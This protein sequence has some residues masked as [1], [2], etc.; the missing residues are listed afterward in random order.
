MA[1]LETLLSIYL[2]LKNKIDALSLA[3]QTRMPAP[4]VKSQK[5]YDTAKSLIGT[6]VIPLTAET[7]YGRLGCAA[8]VNAVVKT[9]I[10]EYVGGGAS[11]ALML[12]YL[13][14][15]KRFEPVLYKD[16]QPGDIV[17]CATGKSSR[18]PVAHGHVGICGKQWIMSNSSEKGTWEANYTYA[19]WKAHYGD[20][21][22]FPI[23]VFRKI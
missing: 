19:T 12:A 10:G 15:L 1:S 2:Q 8:S 7:D 18:Y 9:A 11:T 6:H 13:M 20:A 23:Q 3:M 17:I 22:G 5:I 21:M 4:T 14:D 16:A